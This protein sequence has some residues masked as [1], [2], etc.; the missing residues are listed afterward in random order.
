MTRTID[1]QLEAEQPQGGTYTVRVT[2]DGSHTEHRVD[3]RTADYRRLSGGRMSPEELLR[4]TFE[5]LLTR[6]P[7]EAILR[8]FDLAVVSSY[9][10]EF[11]QAIRQQPSG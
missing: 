5:F 1:V 7:K 8:R 2:E 4:R 6:E 9:F 3:L 10:P 11:E